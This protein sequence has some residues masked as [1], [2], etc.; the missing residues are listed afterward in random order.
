MEQ[1]ES[2]L[3]V[4]IYQ[5]Y[6]GKYFLDKLTFPSYSVSF[7][8]LC[9]TPK[10]CN[11][12]ACARSHAK[13]RKQTQ[14]KLHGSHLLHPLIKETTDRPK[15]KQRNKKKASLKQFLL[16]VTSCDESV[17]SIPTY[18]QGRIISVRGSNLDS[19]EGYSDQYFAFILQFTEE[20]LGQCPSLLPHR[21]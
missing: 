10:A 11:E 21:F 13:R 3:S 6:R 8:A 20:T 17:R 1:T 2:Y 9:L 14:S 16:S 4:I 7:H 18:M 5:C 15:R 19:Q 12:E